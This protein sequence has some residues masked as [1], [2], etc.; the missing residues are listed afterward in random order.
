MGVATAAVDE[1][2]YQLPA[3]LTAEQVKA[4][5]AAG[6]S[7]SYILSILGIVLLVRNLPSIF[8]YDPVETAKE[9]EK[10]FGAEGHALPGTSAAF[11]AENWKVSRPPPPVIM[12]PPPPPEKMMSLWLVPTIVSAPVEPTSSILSVP[13]VQSEKERPD[14][15]RDSPGARLMSRIW[16]L[17]SPVMVDVVEILPAPNWAAAKIAVIVPDVSTKVIRSIL[18]KPSTPFDAAPLKSPLVVSWRVSAPS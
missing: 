11:E 1:G 5:I 15:S 4:N 2:L 18:M 9:S 17:E 7:L 6:Y 3:G 16:V 8:G 13:S 10:K 14:R 12:S